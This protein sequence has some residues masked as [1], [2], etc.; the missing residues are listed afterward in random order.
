MYS[1]TDPLHPL[2]PLSDTETYV[3]DLE[4]FD[5]IHCRRPYYNCFNFIEY[6][7]LNEDDEI[8]DSIKI[9]SEPFIGELYKV[10]KETYDKIKFY[11][12]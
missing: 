2:Y 9:T 1:I 3:I 6:Y 11:M 7:I 8:V 5:K 12:R 10:D 4:W